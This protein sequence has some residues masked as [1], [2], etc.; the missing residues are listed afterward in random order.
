MKGTTPQVPRNTASADMILIRP[1]EKCLST[2]EKSLTPS[3]QG[4]PILS[5]TA[6]PGRLWVPD[7]RSKGPQI[8][9]SE[10][11]GPVPNGIKSHS[12]FQH[13]ACV[14]EVRVLLFECFCP[15]ILPSW[16]VD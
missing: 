1:L 12:S 2:Q 5:G 3:S 10:T 14:K 16:D 7:E 11:K 4:E 9:K 6:D 13:T 8:S 15:F